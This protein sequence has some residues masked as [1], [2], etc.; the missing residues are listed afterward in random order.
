MNQKIFP[1]F[2][3]NH[4]RLQVLMYSPAGKWG[5]ERSAK[6]CGRDP[7][8]FLPWRPVLAREREGGGG[9]KAFFATEEEKYLAS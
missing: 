5:T 9:L 8:R 4:L 6:E 1:C 2:R 7:G 3:I